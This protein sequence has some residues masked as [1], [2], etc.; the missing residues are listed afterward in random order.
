M[1]PDYTRITPLW[2]FTGHR[3]S[4]FCRVVSG[5]C[6]RDPVLSFNVCVYRG[7]LSRSTLSVSVPIQFT[8]LLVYIIQLEH[9]IYTYLRA[10]CRWCKLGFRQPNGLAFLTS[11][12]PCI[13]S[14]HSTTGSGRVRSRVKS[15]RVKLGH[16]S[17]FRPGS[18]CELCVLQG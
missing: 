7:V 10:D 8:T 3:V 1:E 12:C 4:D 11:R 5:H 18:I 2:S 15:H 6:V 13:V 17:K 14:K 9:G 16:G